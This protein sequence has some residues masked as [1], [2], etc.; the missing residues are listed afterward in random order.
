MLLHVLPGWG[1]AASTAGRDELGVWGCQFGVV[2]GAPGIQS[3]E[4]PCGASK[5]V[6]AEQKHS[7]VQD[8]RETGGSSAGRGA[9]LCFWHGLVLGFPG[10]YHLR[11]TSLL[12]FVKI[13]LPT[14]SCVS[15]YFSFL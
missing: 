10:T 9:R 4:L 7:R 14:S 11:L 6:G 12:T 8:P 5:G 2:V 1:W 13:S 15:C 3:T